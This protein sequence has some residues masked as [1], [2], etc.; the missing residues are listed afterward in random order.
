MRSSRRSFLLSCVSLLALTSGAYAIGGASGIFSSSG[1]GGGSVTPASTG[2]M[3]MNLAINP[4]FSG[5]EPATLNWITMSGSNTNLQCAQTCT[6]NSNSTVSYSNHN[7]SVSSA[8]A[9]CT[10]TFS[11]GSLPSG[12]TSGT[13]YPILTI[14]DANNVTISATNGGAQL[15]WTG[16][17]TGTVTGTLNFGGSATFNTGYFDTNAMLIAPCPAQ[18]KWIEWNFFS[19]P[20]TAIVGF[21]T[22]AN[23][24]WNVKWSGT[25]T[26]ANTE[27]SSYGSGGGVTDLGTGTTATVATGASGFQNVGVRLNINS[28]STPPTKPIVYLP[29]WAANVAAG[30]KW[31]P[32]FLGSIAPFGFIRCMDWMSTNNPGPTDISQLADFNYLY[33]TNDPGGITSPGTNGAQGAKYGVH[34]SVLVDLC[35]RTGCNLWFNIPAE[36]TVAAVIAVATYFKANLRSPLKVIWQLANEIWNTNLSSFFY[37]NSLVYPGTGTTGQASTMGGYVAAQMFQ[38]I[39]NVYGASQRSKW[40]GVLDGQ[41]ADQTRLAASIA[42]AKYYCSTLATNTFNQLCDAGCIAPYLGGPPPPSVTVTSITPGNPTTVNLSAA[43]P[44]MWTSGYSVRLFVSGGTG[45]SAVN[46]QSF[47]IT[48]TGA[49]QFTVPVNTTGDTF[50]GTMYAADGYMFTIFDISL[51]NFNSNP[52]TYPTKYTYA[53]NQFGQ[54]FATGTCTAGMILGATTFTG[55]GSIASGEGLQMAQNALVANEN[56]LQVIGYEGGT[57]GAGFSDAN[58]ITN[59]QYGDYITNMPF[60]NGTLALPGYALGYQAEFTAWNAIN[61]QYPAQYFNCLPSAWCSQKSYTDLTSGTW[62]ALLAQNALGPYVDPT[63]P[64]TGTLTYHPPITANANQNI[65][66]TNSLTYAANFGSAGS[67]VVAV[68]VQNQNGSV[69]SVSVNSTSLSLVVQNG[70]NAGIYSAAMSWG[71]DPQTITVT[72]SGAASA[73]KTAFTFTMTGLAS[74]TARTTNTFSNG[75]TISETKQS[76]IL[77]IGN[78]SSGT[79]NWIG[80][81]AP[82]GQMNNLP[83]FQGTMAYWGGSPGNYPVNF[84]STIFAVN[85]QAGAGVAVATWR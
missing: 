35:N 81:V 82:T 44:S 37:F 23:T 1:G 17:S 77:A 48:V 21:P 56:G 20:G 26:A 68:L 70:T 14:V 53:A 50:S 43:P 32:N 55:N 42:G 59:T 62:T 34:P 13:A 46:N 22:W 18:V 85:S 30:E 51:S 69:V 9:G 78:D 5:V 28:V 12:I 52:S 47:T 10:I 75:G 33:L 54:A 64:A 11:G 40:L 49:Q 19:P 4:Y 83:F 36:F 58:L 2:G 25:A 16:T 61:S 71:A 60:E 76:F 24:T 72:Y 63:L 3:V 84:T 7:T 29:K 39:Y 80:S 57:W 8:A 73:V 45:A 31:N 41:L 27:F 15:T 65:D 67:G 66:G 38:A 6:L 79:A 74:N